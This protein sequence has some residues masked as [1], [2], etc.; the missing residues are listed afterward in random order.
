LPSSAG[1]NLS[2][3]QGALSS[4]DAKWKRLRQ[5]SAVGEASFS[6]D[7]QKSQE[8]VTIKFLMDDDTKIDG[9]LNVGTTATV[10]RPPKT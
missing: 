6:V 5:V 7:V 3:Q 10:D 9:K 2:G 1:R 8:P 4:G